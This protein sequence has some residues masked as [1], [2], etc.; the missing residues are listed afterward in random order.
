MTLSLCFSEG[1]TLATYHLNTATDRNNEEHPDGVGENEICYYIIGKHNMCVYETFITTCNLNFDYKIFLG[2]D[3]N[4][5]FE[6]DKT[7]NILK[8]VNAVDRDCGDECQT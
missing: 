2:G 4:G 5:Y 3:P 1:T 6:T 7:T 8:V